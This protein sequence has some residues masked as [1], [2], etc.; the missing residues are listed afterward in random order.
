M[1][2]FSLLGFV[3]EVPQAATSFWG[4]KGGQMH[5]FGHANVDRYFS[6]LF[7]EDYLDTFFTQKRK[8]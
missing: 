1:L 4:V 6:Q 7:N 2:T 5:L 3:T 8:K